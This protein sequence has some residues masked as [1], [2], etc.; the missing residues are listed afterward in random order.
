MYMGTVDYMAPEQAED[1]RRADHRA[2][3]YSL[4][5]TLH[6]LLTGR[7]PFVGDTILKRLMAH[8]ERRRRC[9]GLR[10]PEIPAALED[11]FQK[12]MAK[13]P[14]DR[15]ESMTAV[16]ALLEGCRAAAAEA[17]KSSP[18]LMVFDNAAARP[19]EPPRTARDAS[20]FAVRGEPEG[21]QVGSELSLEDLVMDIRPAAP[22][23]PPTI[24][25]TVRPS[26]TP[27]GRSMP[28]ASR[29]PR[30]S[31]IWMAVNVLAVVC[32]LGL[33]GMVATAALTWYRNRAPRP[34]HPVPVTV[35]SHEAEASGA[36]ASSDRQ[37]LAAENVTNKPATEPK[38][39]SKAKTTTPAERKQGPG[40]RT[41]PIDG[42]AHLYRAEF[43]P[44]GKSYA[45]GGDDATIRLYKTDSGELIRAIRQE[46]WVQSLHFSGDGTRLFSVGYCK[47]VN[48]WDVATGEN[49]GRIEGREFADLGSVVFAPD[50][51]LGICATTPGAWNSGI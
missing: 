23:P 17:P 2:D 40:D 20:I 5:C 48:I 30:R 11:A 22:P 4:G 10:A 21:L 27:P 15:L 50:G 14:A 32:T 45:T 47:G 29:Q 9:C 31:A 12:M 49:R 8:Q 37:R 7:E 16:I 39:T 24:K 46:G 13:R 28:L 41:R 38:T 25:R 36:A 43:A 19:A 18:R 51:R 35:P 44:D 6:Y 42:Q 26:A 33:V 34:T 1:S 3:I